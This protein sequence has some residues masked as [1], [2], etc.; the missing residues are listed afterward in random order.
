MSSG[1]RCVLGVLGAAV[2]LVAFP[3]WAADLGD[4]VNIHGYGGWAYGKTDGNIYL[5]GDKEG[6]YDNANFAL[7]VTATPSER[8]TIFSQFEIRVDEDGEEIELDFAFADW[9]L[10]GTSHFR[11]GQVKQPFGIYTELFDVGTLRP[12]L[13]LPQG[14]YGP[15][16]IVAEAYRGKEEDKI[17]EGDLSPGFEAVPTFTGNRTAFGAHVEYLGDKLWAR[18]EYAA[19]DAGEA[20][21]SGYYAELAYKLTDNWQV[22][23]RCDG[24]GLDGPEFNPVIAPTKAFDNQDLAAA[25]DYWFSPDMVIKLEYHAVDGTRFAGPAPDD[26]YPELMAGTFDTETK[27]IQLGVNFSC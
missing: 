16:G 25:V 17:E 15:Q 3:G 6:S 12:L 26:F 22:A 4:A 18:A 2:M 24:G 5:D 13:D 27:L 8:L 10:G 21:F 23:G 19:L 14:I 11:I 9:R 20:T 1:S 7:N